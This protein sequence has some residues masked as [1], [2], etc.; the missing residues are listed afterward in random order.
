MKNLAL[1]AVSALFVAACTPKA[2]QPTDSG[3][4]RTNFQTEVSQ[5]GF[6]PTFSFPLRYSWVVT[7]AGTESF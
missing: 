7:K 6:E 3:L 5:I 2:E 1:W 4:L